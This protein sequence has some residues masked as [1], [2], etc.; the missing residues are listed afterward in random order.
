MVLKS[1]MEFISRR[2]SVRTYLDKEI[3]QDVYKSLVEVLSN[4]EK[5][6]GPFGHS[7]RYHIVKLDGKESYRGEKLGTYGFIKGHKGFV[8]AVCSR[9]DEAIVDLGYSFEK[10]IIRMTELG[11]G[12][13]W[14]GGTFDR[15]VFMKFID[16]KKNEFIPAITPFGYGTE[17]RRMKDKAIRKMAGADNRKEWGEMFFKGDFGT[18]LKPADAGNLDKAFEMVRIG[19]S[20]S[21]K[22]PW[23]IVLS[24]DAAHFYL[25]F[26]PDY[27][28]NKM[29]F[30]MQ[31]L[32]IGIAMCHFE[33]ACNEL[34]RN[35]KWAFN[36]P[37]IAVPNK[38]YQY[39]ASYLFL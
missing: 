32:D 5:T 29:G 28:G 6:P 8:A 33:L 17:K 34:G 36:R 16:V 37:E 31:K 27:G 22:Q 9:E 26:N 21:N 23:R 24:G 14:L 4:A 12:T 19:P 10:I 15:D 13:C 25:D 38:Q 2:T 20:A 7:S 35:G 1:S 11:L 3:G 30:P 18:E 39:I